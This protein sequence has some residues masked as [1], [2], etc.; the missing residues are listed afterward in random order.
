MRGATM[1]VIMTLKVAGNPEAVEQYS[2]DNPGKLESI[3]EA[4]KLHGIM[5]HR[6]YGSEDGAGIMVIDEWPD[7]QSFEAFFAEQQAEIQPLMD[8]AGAAGRPEAT[9]W[10]E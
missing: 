4:A 3:G 10:H 5:A 1:S 2:K 6:F 8:A 9:F 7:R